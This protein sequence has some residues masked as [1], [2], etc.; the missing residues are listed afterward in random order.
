MTKRRKIVTAVLSFI[1]IGTL[2]GVVTAY[3]ASQDVKANIVTVGEDDISV[4]ENFTPPDQSTQNP[5]R[6]LV[7]IQNTGSI[8]CYIRVRLEF[9]SSELRNKALF[10]SANQ[11][12]DTAPDDTAFYS[13]NPNDTNAYINH[14]PENWVY[15]PDG[16]SGTPTVTGGYYYYT[17]PV[18]PNTSTNALLSWVKMNYRDGDEKPAHNIY[19]Y[20]ESVQTNDPDS[21]TVYSGDNGWRNA[22]NSFAG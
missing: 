4:T 10:S 5:Y 9:S 8:P 7:K 16:D 11:D 15:V 1:V 18:D 22:W 19:V 6:K 3:F 13:A 20:S 17:K 14:L 21:G 12:T 2:V